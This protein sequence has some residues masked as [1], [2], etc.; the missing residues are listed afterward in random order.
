VNFTKKDFREEIER[1]IKMREKVYPKWT[2][3]GRLT[4]AS[5]DLRL[6]IMRALLVHVQGCDAIPSAPPESPAGKQG[7]LF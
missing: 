1:E 6:A 7:R 5:A 4:K 2:E 3:D